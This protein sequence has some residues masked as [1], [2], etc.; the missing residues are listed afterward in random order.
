MADMIGPAI[1][2]GFVLL[3]GMGAIGLGELKEWQ[4]RRKKEKDGR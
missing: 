4:Y 1:F 2:F 3:A